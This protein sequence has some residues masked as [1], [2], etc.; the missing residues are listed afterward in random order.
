MIMMTPQ[1]ITSS[2][3]A[4]WAWQEHEVGEWMVSWLVA[5]PMRLSH[6]LLAVRLAEY[7]DRDP[8]PNTKPAWLHSW[9]REL[10]LSVAEAAHRIRRATQQAQRLRALVA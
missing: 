5:P 3:S 4:H 8:A 1:A 7:L 10:D 6:A 2:I 9:A